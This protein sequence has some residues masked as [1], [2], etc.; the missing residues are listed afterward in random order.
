MNGLAED[1]VPFCLSDGQNR[2]FRIC[3]GGIAHGSRGSCALKRCERCPDA[4]CDAVRAGSAQRGVPYG[5]GEGRSAPLSEI[6]SGYLLQWAGICTCL[7][8]RRFA[9]GIPRKVRRIN[10]ETETPASQKCRSTPGGGG[11]FLALRQEL[12]VQ[13]LCVFDVPEEGQSFSG[14]RFRRTAS[15]WPRLQNV[16]CSRWGQ[17]VWHPCR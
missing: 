8:H 10:P 13:I 3:S 1:I 17:D 4:R 6:G 7:S 2:C 14:P 16:W 12:C 9:D 15:G 11:G 5:P